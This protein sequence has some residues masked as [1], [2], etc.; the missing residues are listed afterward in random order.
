MVTI[1]WLNSSRHC[2]RNKVHNEIKLLWYITVIQWQITA[3]YQQLIVLLRHITN[4]L[5]HIMALLQQLTK[6][7]IQDLL[8]P[9]K[10]LSSVILWVILSG[11][12]WTFILVVMLSRSQDGAG[13]PA[14]LPHSV[15][16]GHLPHSVWDR[17]LF[18]HCLIWT[19]STHSH[20][21]TKICF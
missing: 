15:W 21:W 3:L 9:N 17:D 11:L 6:F 7:I 19:F 13:W 5:W 16:D 14:H 10:D 8:L 18:T 4:L 2:S 12:T 1:L 20:W